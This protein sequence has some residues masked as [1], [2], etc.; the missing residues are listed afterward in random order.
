MARVS[1]KLHIQTHSPRRTWLV[2]GGLLALVLVSGYL[3]FELGRIKA[4][5]DILETASE[6]QSYEDRIAELEDEITGFKQEVALL[7]T[8]RDIDRK[9]YS[10]VESSLSSLQAKIVEQQDALAFYR[11]IVSPAD[12]KPGLRVQDLTLTRGDEE[13]QFNLRLVLVQS[14][15]H[16]RKVSGEVQ[17]SVEGSQDGEET[18]YQLSQL[19]PE[20]ADSGWPFSFRY[21]QN[22]DRRLLLPD[23]FTP[24]QIRVEVRSKT[25]SIADIEES[26]DWVTAQG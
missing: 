18:V 23:G 21:F 12:G 17:L 15:Q 1:R 8:H 4:G 2:R 14:L 10:E 19:L 6:R 3:I 25:R 11:G 13:R 9:A 5:Y 7:E 24:R 26:F 22:F 20:D 16:D